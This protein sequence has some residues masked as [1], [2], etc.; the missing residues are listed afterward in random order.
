MLKSVTEEEVYV[1]MQIYKSAM[2]DATSGLQ[3]P[4]L[5]SS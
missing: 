5:S 4:P 3:S 1:T 2:H